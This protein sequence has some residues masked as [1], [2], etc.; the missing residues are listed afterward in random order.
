MERLTLAVGVTVRNCNNEVEKQRLEKIKDI[1]KNDMASNSKLDLTYW[2]QKKSIVLP[3]NKSTTYKLFEGAP[4]SQWNRKL[5]RLLP[6]S[7]SEP[8]QF[9]NLMQQA[10]MFYEQSTN[11][12]QEIADDTYMCAAFLP[13]KDIDFIINV[14]IVVG[15]I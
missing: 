8:I 11:I 7:A 12:A 4:M 1:I 9:E 5:T 3:D 14:S 2:Q 10:T 13:S 15:C 6:Q